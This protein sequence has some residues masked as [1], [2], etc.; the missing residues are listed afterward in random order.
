[1]YEIY[2]WRTGVLV[3]IMIRDID[4]DGDASVLSFTTYPAWNGLGSNQDFFSEKS[5]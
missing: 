5:I 1:M 3:M 4:V 2:V